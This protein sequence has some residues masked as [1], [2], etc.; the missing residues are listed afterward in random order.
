MA[1]FLSESVELLARD[2]RVLRRLGPSLG[3]LG[4]G[5]R[6]R[7]SAVDD[8]QEI[9]HVDPDDVPRLVTFRTTALA[10]TPGWRGSLAYRL[11]QSDGIRRTYAVDVVNC[12]DDPDLGG[13]VATTRELS[14]VPAVPG[15]VDGEGSDSPMADSIAEAVPVALVVL[16]AH[17]RM[18]FANQAARTLCDLPCGTVRGRYLPDLAVES[19]RS[20]LALA[21]T[22]LLRHL[23]SRVVVF[24]TR[25]WQGRTDLR[26][27]EARLLARGLDGRP[28]TVIVTL[29]DVTE[30][31]REEED[32][33]RRASSDPL[34]GLLNRAALLEE[35]EARLVNGPVT[36]IYCD[37]DGFKSINDTFGH[38]WGDELLVEFANLLTSIA[39][40]TDVIGRLGGDEFVVVCDGLSR[41]HTATLVARLGSAFDEGLAARVSVGVASSRGGGAATDLLARADRA[42]YVNKR[43]L[44]NDVVAEI[45]LG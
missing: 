25:G 13:I 12:L 41:S 10:S 38:A 21:V 15:H 14:P 7:G 3:V 35:V 28:S 44:A 2:G 34:T 19:D 18:E 37:L 36:A 16:D 31:R 20:A 39:R 22:Q 11:R 24:A 33:R 26:L 45:T 1:P 9:T 42:M 5:D 17:G 32:L 40:S 29:D 27:I 8:I 23:G 43:R 30:R 4:R 6:A